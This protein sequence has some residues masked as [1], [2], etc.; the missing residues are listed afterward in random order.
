VDQEIAIINKQAADQVISASEAQRQ[1]TAIT[2]ASLQDQYS[3]RK[4]A[5]D[6]ALQIYGNDTQNTRRG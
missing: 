3:A 5:A 1:I 4:A 2:V 6:K